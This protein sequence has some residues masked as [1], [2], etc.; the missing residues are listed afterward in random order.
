MSHYL[1]ASGY[2]K[3]RDFSLN[4]PCDAAGCWCPQ[5]DTSFS[6]LNTLNVLFKREKVSNLDESGL[7]ADKMLKGPAL[8]QAK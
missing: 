1:L 6:E 4:I 8:L 7:T 3:T 2:E 5:A